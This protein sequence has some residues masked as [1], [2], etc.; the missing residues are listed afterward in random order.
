VQIGNLVIPDAGIWAFQGAKPGATSQVIETT[1]A[2]YVFR[3]DSLQPEGVPPLTQIRR[4]VEIS[5]KNERKAKLARSLAEDFLKRVEGGQSMADAAKVMNLPTKEFGPFSRVD[6]PLNNPVVVGAAFGLDVGQR[7]GVLDTKD[8]LYVIQ[9]LEHT[10]A[11][12]GQFLKDRESYR[13]K[14]VDLARQDRVRGY[15][16]ALREAAKVVD[17]RGRLQQRPQQQQQQG[18]Q[19]PTSRL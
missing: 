12:S 15:L 5:L 18:Q 17:N 19:T 6:P 1:Y 9:V 16:A 13:A 2:F 14:L 7:S 4:A 3:V 11:D 8:G 10:K